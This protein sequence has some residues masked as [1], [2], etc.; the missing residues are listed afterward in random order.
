MKI[1]F[2]DIDGVI[3]TQKSHCAFDK[4]ACDLF[5][6]IIDATDAKIA[7]TSSWRRNAVEDTSTKKQIEVEPMT[8]GE[9][10]RNHLIAVGEKLSEEE[11]SIEGYHTKCHR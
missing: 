11:Q 10:N 1:I 4:N 5:G 7:I 3:P 9:A 8:M 2:L 6:E